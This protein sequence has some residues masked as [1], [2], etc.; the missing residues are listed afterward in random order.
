MESTPHAANA[1]LTETGTLTSNQQQVSNTLAT[2]V[3]FKDSVPAASIHT[4]ATRI[5]PADPKDL[6]DI[7]RSW[8]TT[9]A[10]EDE[11]LHATTDRE[12]NTLPFDMDVPVAYSIPS[13]NVVVQQRVGGV[14]TGESVPVISAASNISTDMSADPITSPIHVDTRRIPCPRLCGA[15]FGP[16]GLA[17]F[18]NGQVQRMWAWYSSTSSQNQEDRDFANRRAMAP[19]EKR[20]LKSM[21]D[22]QNM[23]KAAKDAQWGEQSEGEASSVTSQQLGLGFFEDGDSDD[24]SS[25]SGEADDPDEMVDLTAEKNKG[26]YETYFGDFRRPLTR[27]SSAD[28]RLVRNISEGG[29]SLGGPSSDMLAPVVKVTRAFENTVMHGQSRQL[30]IGWELGDLSFD[31]QILGDIENLDALNDETE[32]D[33]SESHPNIPSALSKSRTS[34]SLFHIIF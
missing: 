5:V 2:G 21:H 26:M 28:S 13:G 6:G 24:D 23:M 32:A 7:A 3:S 33:E 27:A 12:H 30:A 22:L 18:G 17:V 8:G 15:T 34:K 4:A 1:K 25:D 20:V 19:G 14:G 11:T 9:P 10:L 31:R 16:G 29:D